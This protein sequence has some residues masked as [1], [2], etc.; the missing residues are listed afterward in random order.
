MKSCLLVLLVV[1]AAASAAQ[2]L[3]RR[4]AVVPPRPA[5]PAPIANADNYAVVRGQTLTV[6]AASGVLAND[7]DPQS[8]PLTA[9]LVSG[10]AHGTL[11]LNADG[12]FTYT[13]DSSSATSDAFT[14][15]ANN[16]TTTSSAATVTIA[17]NDVP[18]V[19]VADSFTLASATAAALINAPGVLGNDTLNNAAIVSY[20]ASSGTEQT[21]VGAATATTG[22]GSVTLNANGSI[23]Y[24][25]PSGFSGSDT[26]KYVIRNSG[27]SSTATVT[28]NAPAQ[29]TPDFFVK[30][31][32]FFYTFSGVDGSNPVITLT[33]GRT[34]R[35]D[36]DTDDIHPFQITGAPSGS[37]INNNI[38]FGILTFTVPANAQNYAYRCSIHG[39]GNTIATVP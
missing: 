15:R 29:T 37:V 24:N 22:G 12:S 23:A 10:V 2:S 19:A 31:P 17:I 16:G 3:G 25:P 28:L 27:G 1:I 20:G 4:R 34:Y 38:S 13:N 8:K 39:F 14:Y 26:F 21:T 9:A 6:A 11:T 30:S 18:P 5:A 35:F 32:G 7:S 36:I 33:R